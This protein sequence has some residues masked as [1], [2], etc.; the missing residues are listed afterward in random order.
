V[1]DDHAEWNDY[2]GSELADLCETEPLSY[3]RTIGSY[4]VQRFWSNASAK[5]GH[6]PCVPLIAAPYYNSVPVL[7]DAVTYASNTT[8]TAKGVKVPLGTSKTIQVQLFSD[9]PTSDWTLS[10]Q[11]ASYLFGGTTQLTFAWDQTS[12]NNGDTRALTITRVANGPSGA[13]EFAI[14]S[15]QSS[16]SYHAYYGIAG[17]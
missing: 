15:T 16:S 13:T 1:D 5:N 10:A 8:V 6:D 12:G 2:P 3:V 17:N 9:A 14:Y 4:E 11:D 7:N